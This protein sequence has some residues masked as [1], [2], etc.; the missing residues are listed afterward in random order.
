MPK[1]PPPS[2]AEPRGAE[3]IRHRRRRVLDQKRGLQR[4][5][6]IARERARLGLVIA[7]R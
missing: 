1:A 7:L 3:R 5:H 6:Q 2:P 4:Q